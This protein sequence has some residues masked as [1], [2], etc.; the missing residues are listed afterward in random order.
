MRC[1]RLHHRMADWTHSSTHSHS[2]HMGGY[3]DGSSDRRRREDEKSSSYNDICFYRT[4]CRRTRIWYCHI[5]HQHQTQQFPLIN[6]ELHSFWLLI[7]SRDSW[8]S[9]LPHITYIMKRIYL[10]LVIVCTSTHTLF[11][12]ISISPGDIGF[13]GMGDNGSILKSD[14]ISIIAVLSLGQSVLLRLILPIVIIGASLYIAYELFTADGDESKMKKA[15]KSIGYTAIALI[16][17]ALSYWVVSIVS[18]LSV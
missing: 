11:A 18:R 14:G 1:H 6:M 10:F 3:P 4:F 8:S 12:S 13:G 7:Y 16:A 5:H 9:Y 2:N 15:W 17:V